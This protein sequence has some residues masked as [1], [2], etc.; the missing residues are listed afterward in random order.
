MRVGIFAACF[1]ACLGLARF[2][3][4]PVVGKSGVV[5]LAL[6]AALISAPLSFI[7]LSKQRDE[8][9]AQIADKVTDMRSHVAAQNAHED[10]IDE[11]N[12]AAADD[13]PASA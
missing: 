1:L 11:A 6:L 3:I 12:R 9:S 8:M 4:L 5:F 2:D 13:R 7:L 10:A